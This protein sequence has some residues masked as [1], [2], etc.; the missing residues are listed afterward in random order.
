MGQNFQFHKFRGKNSNVLQSNVFKIVNCAILLIHE[1]LYSAMNKGMGMAW[2]I[3]VH[4]FPKK[5]MTLCSV[6][7]I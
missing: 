5:H 7:D 3:C 2:H 1:V 6:H 4:D